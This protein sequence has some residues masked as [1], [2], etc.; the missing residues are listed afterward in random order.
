MFHWEVKI[1]GAWCGTEWET[2]VP[3][4]FEEFCLC[5]LNFVRVTV[6]YV[7]KLLFR[8]GVCPMGARVAVATRHS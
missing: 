8:Q 6:S 2:D 7:S 1:S 4:W 5:G 3:K